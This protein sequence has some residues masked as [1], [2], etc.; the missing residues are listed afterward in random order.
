MKQKQN[1]KFHGAQNEAGLKRQL[2]E[3]EKAAHA[4]IAQDRVDTYGFAP[5][6]Q[7]DAIL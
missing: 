4:A 2:A 1:E 3:I 6:M 7:V 5:S